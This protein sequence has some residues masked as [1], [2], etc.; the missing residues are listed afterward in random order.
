MLHPDTELRYINDTIGY[1]VF[2]TQL[3]PAGTITWARDDLDQ[4]FTPQQVVRLPTHLREILD[5]Y[6]FYDGEGNWILCWDLARFVNHCCAANCLSAG[7]DF[8]IAVRDILPGEELTDDYGT[9]NLTAPFEC[10][11]GAPTCRGVL[12]PGDPERLVGEWDATV[13]A[14]FSR[15]GKLEQPLRPFVQQWEA[16]QHALASGVIPSCRCHLLLLNGR[17]L[18]SAIPE[19]WL[20]AEAGVADGR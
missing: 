3:I 10:H 9:L 8:E 16:V 11:C 17:R 5:R 20:P 12:Q 6:C 19:R 2:A 14:V 18:A 1:G 15:V 13:R 7:F 4:V